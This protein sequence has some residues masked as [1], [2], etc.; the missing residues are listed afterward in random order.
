[1]RVQ[2]L[3]TGSNFNHILVWLTLIFIIFEILKNADRLYARLFIF[4]QILIKLQKN[5]ILKYFNIYLGFNRKIAFNLIIV[6][7][8]PSFVV[9]FQSYY[10]VEESDSKLGI[11]LRME[12]EQ[13]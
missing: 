11:S 1:L 13:Y 12:F 10:I 4:L 2:S 8:N 5:I 6:R 3:S 9:V 7:I